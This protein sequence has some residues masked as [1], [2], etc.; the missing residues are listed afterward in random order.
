[1]AEANGTSRW[2]LVLTAVGTAILVGGAV[3]GFSS[4][5][6]AMNQQVSTLVADVKNLTEH[7]RLLDGTA[8][9]VTSNAVETKALREQYALVIDRIQSIR[10][11]QT[12]LSAALTEIETQFCA[13][14]HVR[15]LMHAN[16]MRM[17]AMLWHKAFGESM[18][19]DNAYYPMICNRQS[20]DRR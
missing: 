4:A 16:N 11:E 9:L 2:M 19:T 5:T 15:N 6:G 12:K 18:P 8:L 10:T 20:P 14:D 13:S 17:E 3:W 7:S 1:M